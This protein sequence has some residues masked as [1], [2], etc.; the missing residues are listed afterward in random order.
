MSGVRVPLGPPFL[1][2]LY[3]REPH[4]ET[5]SYRAT[6]LCGLDRQ[7]VGLMKGHSES[8]NEPASET[9]VDVHE[10]GSRIRVLLNIVGNANFFQAL[11]KAHGR[12]LQREVMGT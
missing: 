7:F 9:G 3:S 6:D 5:E 10:G 8:R 12:T 11:V 2:S 4:S 1:L